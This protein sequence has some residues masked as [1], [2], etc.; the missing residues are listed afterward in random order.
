MIRE[1]GNRESGFGIRSSGFGVRS[2]EFGVR[3]SEFGVRNS[4]FGIR[5]FTLQKILKSGSRSPNHESRFPMMV[6]R[7][8]KNNPAKTY[9]SRRKCKTARGTIHGKTICFLH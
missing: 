2:S 7:R 8:A 6:L 1:I 5:E 9:N 4:E 3:S